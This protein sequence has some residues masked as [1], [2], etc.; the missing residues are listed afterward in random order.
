MAATR[1]VSPTAS[2]LSQAEQAIASLAPDQPE[3]VRLCRTLLDELKV[4][5]PKYSRRW[6]NWEDML[7][8]INLMDGYGVPWY[9]LHS[10]HGLRHIYVNNAWRVLRRNEKRI[11]KGFKRWRP[12]VARRRRRTR[13]KDRRVYEFSRRNAP[14]NPEEHREFCRRWHGLGRVEAEP[15]QNCGSVSD[16]SSIQ[17]LGSASSGGGVPG[18][19]SRYIS[20]SPT[21]T[22][23]AASPAE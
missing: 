5:A 2:F 21:P 4:H 1:R 9:H 13:A 8:L 14:A 6:K 11:Y 3:L 17:T 10:L 12:P 18:H 7:V 19:R 20:D 23:V 15:Q 22:S 16:A